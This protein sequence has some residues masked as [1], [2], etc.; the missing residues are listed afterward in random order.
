[1]PRQMPDLYLPMPAA[2]HSGALDLSAVEPHTPQ[3]AA[4]AI[5]NGFMPSQAGVVELPGGDVGAFDFVT[6]VRRPGEALTVQPLPKRAVANGGRVVASGHV[7]LTTEETVREVAETLPWAHAQWIDG[8]R[9]VGSMGIRH[10]FG[11]PTLEVEE[12]TSGGILMARSSPR[13][14]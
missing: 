8:F 7:I 12:L 13:Y 2:I 11:A 4:L 5:A 6:V 10:L 1:M 14:F 3:D 9:Q